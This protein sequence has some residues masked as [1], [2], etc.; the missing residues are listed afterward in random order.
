MGIKKSSYPAGPAGDG[1]GLGW[2]RGGPDV[3]HWEGLNL[4]TGLGGLEPGT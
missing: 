4:A 1:V 3:P 2:E